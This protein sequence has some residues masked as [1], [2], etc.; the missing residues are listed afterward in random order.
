MTIRFAGYT[1][2]VLQDALL[3][4]DTTT[5]NNTANTGGANP[6]AN[7]TTDDLQLSVA[8]RINHQFNNSLPKEF[9]L[10]IAQ[11]RNK[12]ALPP[13]AKDFGVRLPPEKYCLTGV[14]WDLS[15]TQEDWM[16]GGD[17]DEEEEEDEPLEPPTA[18]VEGPDGVD[19]MDEDD[20]VDE[21]DGQ[22]E[23]R[24]MMDA[25]G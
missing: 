8:S 17:D 16:E 9:L 24:L 5:T 12:I 15:E 19:E 22:A 20:F 18:P 25:S 2:S 10:E 4:S 13:I 6:P 3:I 1:S 21:G 14:N 23:D 11:E 7:I